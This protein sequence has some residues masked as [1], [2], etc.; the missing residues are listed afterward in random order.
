[1]KKIIYLILI[2]FF[3]IVSFKTVEPLFVIPKGWQKPTYNFTENILTIEKINIGR[4]LFYDNILSKDN[5]ISCSSCHLSYTAFAHTDHDLSHG[6]HN[7]I[8]SRNAPALFNLAW[9]KKLMW[10]GAVNHLDA[11]ALAPIHNKD[12]MDE[13]IAHVV[14]KLNESVLYKKLF[15]KAYKDS[16]ITGEKTL[17]CIAQFLITIQ[18]FNSKYDSVMIHQSLFTNQEANGYQL[19]QKNCSSCHKEPLFT[20]FD[21]ETN[22]LKV[23]ETLNDIGRMKITHDIKDS[24]KFKIPSLRNIEFSSPYMHDGRFKKLMDVLNHYTSSIQQ[25]NNLPESLKKKITLTSNQ[26]VDMIAF[27][28]TLSDKHF[29]F[30]STYQFPKKILLNPSKDK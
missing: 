12:E 3:G 11:Q 24:L 29:L 8:G 1:M 14:E 18:S 28:L 2:T 26:K 17:K 20:T 19:F 16:I 22:G 13:T 27:L 25:Y 7:R 5:S 21:F 10:D 9:S 6:I 23:D 4:S 15:L 30:N